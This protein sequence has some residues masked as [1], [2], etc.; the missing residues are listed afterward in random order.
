MNP[1]A[2]S[3]NIAGLPALLRE[4]FGDR[5]AGVERLTGGVFSRAFAFSVDERD[6]VVRVNAAAHAAES[7]AKD[8]YAWRHFASPALPVPRIVALGE[9]SGW[10]YAIGERV[11]GLPLS[12]FSRA[13]RR[14]ALPAALDTLE[15][16][17]KVDT[18]ASRDYGDWGSDGNGKFASWQ[19][20]L[21]D[22]IEN[23]A[24]GY[25]ADWQRLFDESFL[26]RDVYEAIYERMLERAERCPNERALIHN[27]FHFDNLM[28][29]G[30]RITG[31]LDWSNA[32]YGDPLYDVA[33]LARPSP[34]PG[35][36]YDDS[37]ILRAR[38]GAAPDYDTRL[39]C[40]QLHI[41]LDHL[42]FYAKNDRPADY[43][44][45]RDWLLALHGGFGG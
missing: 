8:D 27:D 6:Y 45:T 42:R 35:W 32:L 38:F 20:Y 4:L 28:A 26:E 29:A 23:H 3:G 21:A 34:D 18:G 14:R 7:F 22:I 5:V 44:F 12:A 43:R 41:G 37:E 13:E 17:G 1:D 2:A 30:E 36:W 9:T 24:D 25:Y 33:W 19:A 11:A 15:E 31:V 40:Y 16:V 10:H 39:T